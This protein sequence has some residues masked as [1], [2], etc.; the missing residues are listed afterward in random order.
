MNDGFH[1]HWQVQSATN[2]RGTVVLVHGICE[3]SGRYRHIVPKLSEAGFT[4][5]SFD[6]RGHGNSPGQRGHILSWSDYRNDLGAFLAFV[7]ERESRAGMPASPFLYGHSM[8]ALITLDFLC[9]NPDAVPA[10]V[11]SGAPIQPAD[12]AKPFLIALANVLSKAW[13]SFPL[14]LVI[15]PRKLSAD[16]DEVKRALRDPLCH[17]RVSARWATQILATIER[18]KAR[19]GTLKLPMLILHGGDDRVNSPDG[20]RWLHDH[21]ASSNK[22]LVIYE[23]ARHEPHND[24]SREQLARDV[25]AWLRERCA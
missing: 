1:L 22:K 12:V 21:I 13:P 18:V 10:A 15:D 3:H 14:P 11:I 7:R 4:V 17:A 24:L 25:V 2:P 23:N 8:G 9:E 5:Y 6:L 16:D 20:A 19:A